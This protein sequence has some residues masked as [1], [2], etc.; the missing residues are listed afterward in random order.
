[1]SA[2]VVILSCDGGGI[3]GLASA[4]ILAELEKRLLIR[5]QKKPLRDYFKHGIIA[6]TSTGS[7]IACGISSG[8]TAAE[9]RDLYLQEGINIFPPADITIKSL[10]RRILSIKI[11]KSMS[12]PIYH[13]VYGVDG[14]KG[15][16]N[17]LKRSFK[18]DL[19]FGSL[20]IPTL[21]TSYDTLNQ[22][23]IAFKS[24]A[25]EFG[26]I[27][28]WE[29]ARASS[30]APV[31]FPAHL[32]NN[33]TFIDYCKSKERETITVHEKGECIPLVDGGLSANNPAMCAVSE[34]LA[35]KEDNADINDIVND[36]VMISLGTGI[37]PVTSKD[38]F[39][40]LTPQDAQ[41]W[42][43]FEWIS[44][45]RDIPILRAISEGSSDVINYQME[46]LLGKGNYFR[47][48]PKFSQSYQA[49]NAN[50]GMLGQMVDDT[51]QYLADPD[52]NQMLDKLVKTLLE[53]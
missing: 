20:E 3:R 38:R 4:V 48:Q 14:I 36:I 31:A 16:N 5:N 26:D 33:E 18:E 28:V 32:L 47:F 42:G 53:E 39:R 37:D 11:A 52:V 25:A 27:N 1:M 30:A 10:L 2:K 51:N 22:Q 46:N 7:I 43:L 29:I 40:Q 21:I 9:I 49:F 19:K 34:I 17:V 12:H 24:N 44:P 35:R 50:E 6:G 13:D 15:I 45:R 23:F 8:R 41:G